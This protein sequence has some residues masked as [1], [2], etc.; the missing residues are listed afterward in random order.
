[1]HAKTWSF[2]LSFH[3]DGGLGLDLWLAGEHRGRGF[4]SAM[5]QLAGRSGILADPIS[6][7]PISADAVQCRAVQYG[8]GPITGG[9]HR[10]D[11]R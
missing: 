3:L 2:T 7:D 11:Q 6:A 5:G 8:V 10:S 1:V 9:R 4:R